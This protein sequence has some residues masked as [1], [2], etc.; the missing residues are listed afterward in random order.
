MLYRDPN[1]LSPTRCLLQN[2]SSIIK[3]TT[4]SLNLL[5]RKWKTEKIKNI[6]GHKQ[7]E[8]DYSSNRMYGESV[9]TI[10]FFLSKLNPNCERLF[11]YPIN[12]FVISLVRKQT[13]QEKHVVQ[14]DATDIR[15]KWFISHLY[16]S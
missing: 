14:H 4:K 5:L 2:V 10:N 1:S 15:E 16:V 8:Q 6:G 11:Q 13:Y 9:S 12:S 3:Q 7:S